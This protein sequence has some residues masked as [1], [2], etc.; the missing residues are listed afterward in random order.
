VAEH[1]LIDSSILIR[2]FG[3]SAP[4]VLA[5]RFS[6]L[7]SFRQGAINEIIELELLV[8]HRSEEEQDRSRERLQALNQL[9]VTAETWNLAARIGLNLRRKG[10]GLPIPDLMIVASAIEHG[11]TIVHADSDFDRVQ[12]N[13]AGLK[14]ESYVERLR[15]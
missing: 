11:A 14:L 13:V 10:M 8:G 3:R 4:E 6:E 1:Y 5:R 2:V 9:T 15:A 7:V 12:G